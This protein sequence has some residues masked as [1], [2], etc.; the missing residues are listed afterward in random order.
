MKG[1]LQKNE[2]KNSLLD[3]YREIPRNKR[4]K[5]ILA[6]QIKFALS[7]AGVYDKIKKN[8][9]RPYEREMVNEVINDGSWEQ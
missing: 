8:N 5:F 9:W 6:L 7:P 2:A 3:W 1:N 4:N